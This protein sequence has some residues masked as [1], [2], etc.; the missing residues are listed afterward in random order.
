MKR[1]QSIAAWLIVAAA[2]TVI[3]LGVSISAKENLK[4][5]S[6]MPHLHHVALKDSA[7]NTIT[8]PKSTTQPARANAYSTA[9]SCAE[10]HEYGT[11]GNGWHFNAGREGV[12]GGRP[13]EPW[14][15]TDT[16]THTQIPLSYRGWKGT[17]VPTAKFDDKTAPPN[18]I[19]MTTRDFLEKFAHHMP[20]GG[21]GE[22]ANETERVE[23]PGMFQIDCLMCHDAGGFYQHELR[24][25]DALVLKKFDQAATVAGGFGTAGPGKAADYDRRR[26]DHENKVIMPVTKSIPNE[27]CYY[28]HTANASLLGHERWMSDRDVH[29]RAGMLCVDCHRE[30]IDHMTVRGYEGEAADRI[31]TDDM[32]NLRAFQ[33]QR[34]DLSLKDDAAK[35]QARG[36]LATERSRISSLSCAGCHM[37]SERDGSA[38]ALA[39]RLGA[40]KPLHVG[41]P[42]IHLEKLSCTACHSGPLPQA[43]PQQVQTAM[44]HMLGLPRQLRAEN[45]PPVIVE[46]VFLRRPNGKITPHRTIW[47]SYWGR[48]GKEGTIR[49]IL[50]NDVATVISD[51]QL[52]PDQTPEQ[53]VRDPYD[54]RPLTDEQIQKILTALA[55]DKTQ[56]EPIFITAGKLYRIVGGK[57][58]SGENK[59][60]EPY[61]WPFG[62][63]VRP[64]REALGA[65]G[66]ADCHS[67]DSPIYFGTVVA[68]GAIAPDAGVKRAMWE[69]RGD[70]KTI[71]SFFAWTFTFRPMLKYIAFTSAAIVAGVLLY[72]G[73]LGVGGMTCRGRNRPKQA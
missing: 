4:T 70:D 51:K 67:G 62:H 2:G 45:T 36:E 56:N 8:M 60:A 1:Y 17:F 33:L 3:G 49:P 42:P 37:G 18:A 48:M 39:G 54:T 46:P 52:I 34:A 73:L 32:I 10:C 38:E 57:L 55:E 9:R 61:A 69:L 23:K 21:I 11:I 53:M 59:A 41:L 65:R 22:P 14:I 50:P 63:D 43:E 7:G 20:G 27:R 19:N 31:V 66:C 13:G 58:T 25:R 24:Y 28:C 29:V 35:A 40:P 68:R 5:E 15:L 64:A 6:R 30:G 71:A 26:F 47:P 16:A 44:A 72:Y 12:S